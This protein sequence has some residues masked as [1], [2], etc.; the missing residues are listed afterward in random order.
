MDTTPPDANW[1]QI[2]PLLDEAMAA[3]GEKDRNAIV[4]RFFQEKPLKEVGATLGIDADTA[5]KRIARALE[6]LRRFFLKRGVAVSAVAITSLLSASVTEAAPVGL[7]SVIAAAAALKTTTTLTA[8]TTTLIEGTLKIM[9]WTKLKTTLV[10]GVGL[11][12]AAGTATVTVNQFFP[13][14]NAA[15]PWQLASI[16]SESLRQAPRRLLILPT[17]AAQRRVEVGRGGMVTMPEGRS[18]GLNQTVASLL[19]FAYGADGTHRMVIDTPLPD[20]RFDLLCN[21]EQG[22]SSALQQ[23]LKHK[24]GVVG[25]KETRETDALL[26]K[27]KATAAPGLQPSAGTYGGMSAGNGRLSIQGQPISSLLR[28]LEGWFGMPVVDRTGLEGRYDIELTYDQSATEQPDRAA[29]QQALLE[30]LGLEV[31]AGRE[32]IEMLIVQKAP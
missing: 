17:V 32:L 11:L 10:A 14:Y 3:L 1:E 6:R 15:Q 19:A 12:L 8:S 2:A 31:V 7:A 4:L 30:Q 26:L 18:L 29:L 13:L 5:Q 23:A 16:S 27:V 24:F 22:N 25:R 9:A 21:L 28:N 20:G